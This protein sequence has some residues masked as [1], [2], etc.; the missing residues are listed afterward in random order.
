M[1]SSKQA[2]SGPSPARPIARLTSVTGRPYIFFERAQLLKRQYRRR[3][4]GNQRTKTPSAFANPL[5]SGATS[6]VSAA[7]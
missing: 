5:D 2:P 4:A 6:K 3:H 7:C 1:E